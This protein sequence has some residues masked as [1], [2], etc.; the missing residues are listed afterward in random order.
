MPIK[1]V[2]SWN[3]M[4]AGYEWK[5]LEICLKRWERKIGIL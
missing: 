2:V 1:N 5:R 3:S 4:I